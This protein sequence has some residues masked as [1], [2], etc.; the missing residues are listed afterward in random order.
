[1]RAV[2]DSSFS[3]STQLASHVFHSETHAEKPANGGARWL[4]IFHI[5]PII[6]VVFHIWLISIFIMVFISRWRS[7]AAQ[8][9]RYYSDQNARGG[10][11]S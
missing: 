2:I 1:M 8:F 10:G 7:G 6:E 11:R 3:L 4:R 5:A 9:S